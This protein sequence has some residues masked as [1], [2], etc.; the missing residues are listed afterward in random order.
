MSHSCCENCD[1]PLT[2]PYCAA[3]G[4]HAHASARSLGGLLHDALHDLTHLEGR[5]WPTLKY[6]LVR[7]GFL[8]LEY[9]AGRRAR[10]AP[11]FR[12]YLVLSV[13]FFALSSFVDRVA[14]EQTGSAHV[15]IKATTAPEEDCTKTQVD[16]GNRRWSPA[17]QHLAQH[18]CERITAD[19]GESVSHT[20]K[21]YVPKTMFVFLPLVAAVLALLY[22]RQRRYYV[23][24]LVFV[25]H[26]HAAAFM[27]MTGMT[28]LRLITVAAEPLHQPTVLWVL[29]GA[30]NGLDWVLLAYIP[31]YT[32]RALRTYYGR[33]RR[34]TMLRLVPLGF[35]Y[36][37]FLALTFGI[38]FLLSAALS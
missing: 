27:A 8:T 9:F 33:P 26:N 7:P 2:G 13:A 29:R 4:Q 19:D 22:R 34:S 11:P 18:M 36:C 21:S 30:K 1:T 15:G 17:A 5:L 24:H 37:F 25:L 31:W 38:A 16:L 6:L 12:L 23:E 14:P 28:L 35:A 3:C 20:F 32:Y 10:Y